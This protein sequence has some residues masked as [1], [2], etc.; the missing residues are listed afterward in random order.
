MPI[1]RFLAPR[2]PDLVLGPV[3]ASSPFSNQ[4]RYMLPLMDGRGKIQLILKIAPPSPC[5]IDLAYFSR[6][7]KKGATVINHCAKSEVVSTPI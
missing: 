3:S 1:K 6:Q 7:N 2:Q 4:H 5:I